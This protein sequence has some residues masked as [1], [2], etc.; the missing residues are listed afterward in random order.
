VVVH[1][2]AEALEEGSEEGEAVLE[3]SG[4]GVA[5]ETSRRLACDAG[6]VEMRHDGA[7]GVLDVGR[8]RRTVPPAIRRALEHRDGGTCRFPGCGCRYTDAHHIRHWAD[9]GETRLDN[10]LSLCRR[11]HRAVHEEGF[12]VELVDWAR[13]GGREGSRL[14][15]GR[16]V[17]V[18]FHRPDGRVLPEVPAPPKA[19][20]QPVEELE[21]AHGERGIEPD[22]WTA[23]SLW[24][25][26]PL[27]LNLALDMHRRPLARQMPAQRPAVPVMSREGL[28]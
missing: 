7:G 21:R 8:K 9:G 2:D 1:V 13:S 28:G 24:G 15:G 16:R 22:G 23:T 20:D 25:G 10:L 14:G 12:R 4:V 3:D 18:R 27:D 6:V 17:G 26:E 5:A 19:P 11:H